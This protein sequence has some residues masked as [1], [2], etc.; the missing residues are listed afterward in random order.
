MRIGNLQVGCRVWSDEVIFGRCYVRCLAGVWR[1][2]FGHWE[3]LRRLGYSEQVGD[4][5]ARSKSQVS[6]FSRKGPFVR[7][8]VFRVVLAD[9]AFE[10][11]F[12]DESTLSSSK[13]KTLNSVHNRSCLPPQEAYPACRAQPRSTL[14][15]D[16]IR[17]TQKVLFTPRGI[18]PE[19]CDRV[20]LLRHQSW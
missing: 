17:S 4:L 12:C 19:F 18:N 15:G 8:Y 11:A 5:H 20:I 16:P 9:E 3:Y 10:K 2:Y 6:R 13:K 7:L 1:R 14:S